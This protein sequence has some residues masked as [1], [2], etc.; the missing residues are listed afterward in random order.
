MGDGD[1]AD[2]ESSGAADA[3]AA[4]NASEGGPGHEEL[5]RD[6]GSQADDM[7]HRSAELQENV[8]STRSEWERRQADE[9]VPG[10]VSETADPTYGT[11]AAAGKDGDADTESDADGPETGDGHRREG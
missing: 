5:A 9:S 8:D 2:T 11:P 1:A 10:A 7:A 3:D 6:M 4:A